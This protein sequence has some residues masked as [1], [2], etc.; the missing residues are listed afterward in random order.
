MR[1]VWLA[2]TAWCFLSTGAKA[3]DVE[4]G[5]YLFDAA[6]C[7]ACHTDSKN[8]GLPLAGGRALSTPFGVYYSPN[9]TADRQYGIG[10]WTEAQFLA[11][12]RHGRSPAGAAYFPVFPYTTFTA[13]SDRD[14][15]DLYAYILSLPAVHKPN[16]DH[17]TGLIFGNRLLAAVW[18]MLFFKPGPMAADPTK[19]ASWNR[20]AYLVEALGHCGECHTPRGR[21]G[22]L[23][24]G[25]N[26]AGT[27]QQPGGALIP[28]ITSDRQTGIGKWSD[29]DLKDLFTIGLLP[30]GDFADGGMAEVITNTTSKWTGDDLAAVIEYLRSLP[31]VINRIAA[32]KT[33]P[34]TW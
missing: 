4:R 10:T 27:R 32:K 15:G 22:N 33:S 13:M 5:H 24:K 20:G 1:T 8:G 31:P 7:L 30:D 28:N 11:A 23:E 26:M 3:G 16:R 9:I 25:Y 17:E 12:L 19:S 29:D 21:L 2:L 18:Q 6:G 14:I 34:A